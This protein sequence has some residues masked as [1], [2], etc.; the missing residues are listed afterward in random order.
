MADSCDTLVLER[1][2]LAAEGTANPRG[3]TEAELAIIVKPFLPLLKTVPSALPYIQTHPKVKQEFY[4]K[5]SAPQKAMYFR[6]FFFPLNISVFP[7][8]LLF[9]FFHFMFSLYKSLSNLD[10]QMHISKLLI[11]QRVLLLIHLDVLQS[12]RVPSFSDVL[13]VSV[14]YVTQQFSDLIF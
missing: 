14:I 12:L 8:E 2:P 9:F 3:P 11:Q 13:Y 4:S 5:P 6:V 10:T 1:A 7:Y